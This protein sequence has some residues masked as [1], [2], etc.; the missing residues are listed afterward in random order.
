MSDLFDTVPQ[1]SETRKAISSA[2]ETYLRVYRSGGMPS[3]LS[4][5]V[6]A[7]YDEFARLYLGEVLATST[8]LLGHD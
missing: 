5:R 3:D 6:Q 7:S 4:S 2:F 8:L 1:V